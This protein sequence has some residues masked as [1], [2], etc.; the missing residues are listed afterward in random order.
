MSHMNTAVETRQVGRAIR[1]LVSHSGR[2]CLLQ[3][4]RLRHP[5]RLL[6]LSRTLCLASPRIPLLLSTQSRIRILLCL[7][8]LM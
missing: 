8:L 2:S 7:T 6:K 3:Q 1:D 5:P 4:P